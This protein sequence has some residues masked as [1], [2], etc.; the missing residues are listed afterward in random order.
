MSKRSEALTAKHQTLMREERD[1][2]S[3]AAFQ[4]DIADRYRRQIENNTGDLEYAKQQ[5]KSHEKHARA[6]D[7]KAL[8]IQEKIN[9]LP[10]RAE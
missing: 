1:M 8:T 6:M 4:R 7:R 10:Q 3:G 5:I 9:R 2:V